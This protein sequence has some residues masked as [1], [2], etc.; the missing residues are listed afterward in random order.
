MDSLLGQAGLI[1]ISLALFALLR[2]IAVIYNK[3][4]PY[5]KRLKN[6]NTYTSITQQGLIE[7]SFLKANNDQM[8]V[9]LYIGIQVAMAAAL[10][11][12]FGYYIGIGKEGFSIDSGIYPHAVSILI[13]IAGTIYAHRKQ[14]G[15]RKDGCDSLNFI[16]M[17]A[18]KIAA[19]GFDADDDDY[20]DDYDESAPKLLTNQS[21]PVAN[22]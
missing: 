14:G 3:D 2:L 1:V 22:L 17:T 12:I 16:I 15:S 20:N 10:F 18:D 9:M 19:E 5:K 21:S 8:K 11:F 7:V 4:R 6:I 13:L